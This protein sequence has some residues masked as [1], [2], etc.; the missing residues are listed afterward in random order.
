MDDGRQTTPVVW[1]KL[2]TGKL[3]IGSTFTNASFNVEPSCSPRE[4]YGCTDLSM[5]YFVIIFRV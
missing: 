3:K 2:L 1:H 4:I 5:H